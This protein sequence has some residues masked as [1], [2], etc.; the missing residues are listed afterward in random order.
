MP[1]NITAGRLLLRAFTGSAKLERPFGWTLSFARVWPG[2]QES[3][4]SGVS[5][6]RIC[7]FVGRPGQS[8]LNE[9]QA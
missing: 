9:H 1:I 3:D 6:H 2:G 7:A 8:R 5:T 4:R